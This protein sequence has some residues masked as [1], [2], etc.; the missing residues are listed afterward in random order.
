MLICMCPYVIV[1][2]SLHTTKHRSISHNRAINELRNLGLYPVSTLPTPKYPRY[3]NY[4]RVLYS[5]WVF[6]CAAEGY[7]KHHAM[8][9]QVL[10]YVFY[11]QP[12][13]RSMILLMW[14]V[15]MLNC[16][17]PYAWMYVSLCLN[18]CFLM[19]ECVCPHGLYHMSSNFTRYVLML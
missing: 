14:Y 18:A 1:C 5:Y 3:N 13:F 10:L 6:Y 16:M 7:N 11:A 2:M 15:L 12:Q 9:R 19:L 17:C 4:V 8:A